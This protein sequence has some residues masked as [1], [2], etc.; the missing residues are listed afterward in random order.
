MRLFAVMAALSLVCASVFAQS[1]P[2]PTPGRPL[3]HDRHDGVTVSIDPYTD[4]ARAKD[5]FGKANPL[6]AGV[7][8]LEVFIR[9][10][11]DQPIRLKLDTIQLEVRY[12]NTGRQDIDWLTPIEVADLIAHPGA[13]NVQRRR[14]PGGIPLPSRDKKT[15][16]LADI[17]RPFAL[18]AD[19][20]PPMAAIHGFLFFNLARQMKL[21]ENASLYVPD[22][23]EIPT[24][25]PLIFFD[26]PLGNPTQPQ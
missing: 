21:V 6:D 15:D 26:V 2:A 3:A 4:L 20:L 19:I 8:P 5:K 1:S 11:T 12:P 7:L 18:D 9:N 23:V 24:N 13:P 17:L 16:K 10:E 14:L 22:L 25:K